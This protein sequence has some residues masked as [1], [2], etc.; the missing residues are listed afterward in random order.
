MIKSK[1]MR[2][3]GHE[4][5]MKEK[6]NSYRIFVGKTEGKS[7][8]GR[9][10]RRWV[11]NIKMYLREIGWDGMNWI[12]LAQES[13]QWR[14]LVNEVMNPGVPCKAGNFLSSC[15]IGTFSRRAQLRE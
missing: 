15:R 11:D 2:W 1:R 5:R 13:G 14:A 12:Y 9:L 6:R 3:A 10:R 8:L 4:G 7:P